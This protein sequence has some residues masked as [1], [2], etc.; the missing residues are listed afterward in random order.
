MNKI[1]IIFIKWLTK[2]LG[3]KL[4]MLK[5][6]SGNIII[7]GDKELFRYVDI[8]GYF[9]KKDPLKREYPK[10]HQPSLV[11]PLTPEQLKELGIHINVDVAD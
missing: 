3:F 5:A 9:F 11:R 8:T 10:P 6:K 7:E 1:C 2:K 4:V